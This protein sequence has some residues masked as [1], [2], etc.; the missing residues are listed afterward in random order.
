MQ[1]M[2]FFCNCVNS[3]KS[4]NGLY[5]LDDLRTWC[6]YPQDPFFVIMGF[7]NANV[8]EVLI[9]R[10]PLLTVHQRYGYA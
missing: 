8:G 2:I 3:F 7:H 6:C 5:F 4:S 10:Q 1:N 9:V